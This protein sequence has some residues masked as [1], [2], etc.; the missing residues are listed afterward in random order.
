MSDKIRV[1]VGSDRSQEL[2]V[3][4]LRY[5][6]EKHSSMPV[7]VISMLEFPV[8]DPEDPRQRKRTGFSFSRFNIPKLCD[9]K[10]KAIYMDA[11]MLVFSDI[12]ELWNMPMNGKKILIQE[13]LS[14]TESNTEKKEQ[15]APKK[16]RKQCAVMVI[17]CEKC[18]WDVDQIVDDLDA[19]K[20]SY[21]ELMLDFCLLSEDEIG[22]VIPF[23][24]NS[25]EHWD[26]TTSNIHYTDVRTQPWV[27]P[28]NDYGY[29]WFKEVQEMIKNGKL[30]IEQIK[31]EIELGYFRPSLLNEL[32]RKQKPKNI[33]TRLYR[34]LDDKL[35]QNSKYVMHKE[36]Y[37]AK[38]Q[39]LEAV[40]KFEEKL[41]QQQSATSV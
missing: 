33:L 19:W 25:Q 39:R 4:V 28:H 18:Q 30:S 31:K 12:A 27:S 2:A 17:D 21:D 41:Q 15:G 32:K 24:W 34:F 3:D 22:F 5:S 29:I 35:D 20:Y 26:E 1:F 6:I 7:E 10:G 36:V 8:R 14:H 37:A 11:D 9:Y 40:K 38:K 23:R 13:D 16:R